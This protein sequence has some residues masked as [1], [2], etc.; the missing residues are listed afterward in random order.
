MMYQYRHIRPINEFR[1]QM[2]IPFDG[3]HPIKDKPHHVHL[4]DA[5]KQM[6]ME[7]PYGTEDFY[8][9]QDPQKLF[10]KYYHDALELYLD[11]NEDF[12]DHQSVLDQ[13][14]EDEDD[15]YW[16][17]PTDDIDPMDVETYLTTK[18]KL[19]FR[20]YMKEIMDLNIL[21]HDFMDNMSYDKEGDGLIDIWRALVFTTG[22]DNDLYRVITDAYDGIG[23]YWAWTESCAYPHG[24]SA[25]RNDEGYI[26]HAK[27][28]PEDI[29]WEQTIFKNAWYLREEQEIETDIKS[30][31]L[32]KS[33][34]AI[35]KGKKIKLND[36]EYMART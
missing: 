6:D 16:S 36:K 5:I 17:K 33:V 25:V 28:R 13:L 24:A 8:S 34:T 11:N 18:G 27:I 30:P 12:T 20:E 23:Y 19:K 29:S 10:N 2:E 4:M 7:S 22:P 31:I 15:G 26:I 35:S 21:D 32:I 14:M 3:K 1:N 9:D